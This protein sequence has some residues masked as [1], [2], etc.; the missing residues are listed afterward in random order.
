MHGKL[1]VIIGG[2]KVALRKLRA[3]LAA[4]AEIRLVAAKIH[5]EIELMQNAGKLVIRGGEYAASD[6]DDA[7]MVIA[8]TDNPLVNMQVCS[9]ARERGILV[10]A[11]DNPGAGDCAFPATLLRGDLEVA[12]S[13]GGRCP[14]FAVDVRDNIAEC[15]SH[16]YGVILE[17][18]SAEREKLLTNGS[19]STYNALVLRSLSRRLL[20][21]LAERKESLS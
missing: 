13:T 3:V 6:L 2:G 18:L 20:A 4:G 19:P 10:N 15:I 17:Q 1:V 11:T 5:P 12:V 16:E 8:A 14:T 21:E 7:F 9:D